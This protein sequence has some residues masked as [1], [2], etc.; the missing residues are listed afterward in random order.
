MCSVSESVLVIDYSTLV[1]LPWR[2]HDGGGLPRHD[3]R[4]LRQPAAAHRAQL[5]EGV[6]RVRECCYETEE[7]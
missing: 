5:E 7:L 3:A 2:R 6:D 1:P 4:A